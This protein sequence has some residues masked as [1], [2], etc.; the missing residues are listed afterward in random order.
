ML[1]NFIAMKRQTPT[2][3]LHEIETALQST[4]KQQEIKELLVQ[5]NYDVEEVKDIL[6]KSMNFTKL[7]KPNRKLANKAKQIYSNDG[8]FIKFISSKS[9]HQVYV[10]LGNQYCLLRVGDSFHFSKSK[11]QMHVIA[12]D[13]ELHVYTAEMGQLV[14]LK[15]LQ[16][17][18]YDILKFHVKGTL[19]K[20]YH[21]K[22]NIA[23]QSLAYN[24]GYP[25]DIMVTTDTLNSVFLC[26]LISMDNKFPVESIE[27]V[28]KI[29]KSLQT[30]KNNKNCH[31][32]SIFIRQCGTEFEK[33]I[34]MVS[35]LIQLGCDAYV[36]YGA[37]YFVVIRSEPNI[38]MDCNGKQLH[39]DLKLI[40]IFNNVHCAINMD[41]Q[42]IFDL[43]NNLRWRVELSTKASL[44]APPCLPAKSVNSSETEELWTNHILRMLNDKHK[45]VVSNVMD[46]ILYTLLQAVED[47]RDVEQYSNMIKHL[48]PNNSNFYGIHHH[49]HSNI[50][51]VYDWILT[52]YDVQE[53]VK[54]KQLFIRVRCFNY[55]GK[56]QSI[57]VFLGGM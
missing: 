39:G 20:R 24:T 37:Q 10:T 57:R 14:E 52:N 12:I 42:A 56:C 53:L 19:S 18:I 29:C 25:D 45:I 30:I 33:C 22:A 46:T 31:L 48:L 8:I 36:A 13:K 51:L 47:Q 4:E 54:C 15:S 41:Q 55:I 23:F 1:C 44:P 50:N 40:L 49:F 26:N 16:N 32:F 35:M 43:D 21:Q 3:L 11:S 34:V 7:I 5:N 6:W 28:V 9:I 2:H 38:Y 27:D 17:M